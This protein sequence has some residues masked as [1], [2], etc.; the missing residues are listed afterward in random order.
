MSRA[1]ADGLIFLLAQ[2][3]VE[4]PECSG[5]RK[6]KNEVSRTWVGVRTGVIANRHKGSF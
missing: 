3:V 2:V 1:I 4:K 6:L 5:S